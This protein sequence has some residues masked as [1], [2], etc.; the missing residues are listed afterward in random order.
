[1][2]ANASFADEPVILGVRAAV[3]TFGSTVALDGVD[4][5]LH[6]GESM[7][8][9]GANGAGKSSLVKILSGA[10]QPDSGELVVDGHVCNLRGVHEARVLGISFVPQELTVAPDLTVAENVLAGGWPSRGG[11][12]SASEGEVIV[13]ATCRRVGL[14]VSP[15]QLVSELSPSER[16][17][18][19]IA[20]GL[21]GDP[22]VLILD[23]PTAALGAQEADRMVEVLTRLREHGLSMV[24]ISHR[25]DEITRLCD[26]VT[27]LRNGKVVMRD[28]ATPDSVRRAVHVGMASLSTEDD[29]AEELHSRVIDRSSVAMR[30]TGLT[31]A[32]LRDVSVAIAVGEIVGVAGLLGSGRTELLRA[33]A[34]ADPVDQGEIEVFGSRLSA[35]SPRQAI[36]AGVALLPEDRRNQGGLLGLSVRENLTMSRPLSRAGW[37]RLKDER[38]HV[39]ECVER[40]GIRCSSPDAL[41]STLSGGNQ[42]KVI[43]ARWLTTGAR[44]LLLDEPT[45]GIDVV[46]KAE[47]MDLVRTAVDGGGSALMVS[48]EL[49][50][51]VGYCDR[52]YVMR[53]GGVL[54]EV[55]GNISVGE[56]ARLCGERVATAS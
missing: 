9:L 36:A 10:A 18:L 33:L 1:M 30:A 35:R 44:I 43:L 51:L 11:L 23:E 6:S 14:E 46:A 37:L 16:R 20:R 22:R 8:L 13:A 45:A 54:Q 17:L 7:A 27:V 24:Y 26:S 32:V 39:R 28:S 4:L 52:I 42:Q 48:S 29:E 53:D 5:S 31:N 3:K 50:E 41:L 25:M 15:R 55:D 21:I 2:T 12:V 34:G 49:D 19:M 56:L 47:L 38:R 40:F